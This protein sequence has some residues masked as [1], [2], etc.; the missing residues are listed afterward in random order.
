MRFLVKLRKMDVALVSL[1]LLSV[2]HGGAPAASPKESFGLALT[3]VRN[4]ANVP[5]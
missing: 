1:V 2:L 3:K 5:V 4:I